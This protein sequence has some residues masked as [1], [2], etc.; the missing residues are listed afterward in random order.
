MLI[1]LHGTKNIRDFSEYGLKNRIRSGHLADLTKEDID[2][3]VNQY[4]LETIIDLRTPQERKEK[5]DVEIE[6]VEHIKISIFDESVPGISHEEQ[7]ERRGRHHIPDMPKLYENMIR[8]EVSRNNLKRVMK[9]LND[10]ERSETILWHCS[11]GK[12]RCG[13]ISALVLLTHGIDDK[14]VMED[15]LRSNIAAEKRADM[16]CAEILKETGD[17]EFSR[18]IRCA[19]VVSEEYIRPV[20]EDIKQIAAELM[21]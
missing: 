17:E 3:L 20:F 8:N 15:Y 4:G 21:A 19:F 16:L 13:V 7:T 14:T 11:E 6:G 9:I 18:N 2:I 12:D 5:P 10:P 1:E